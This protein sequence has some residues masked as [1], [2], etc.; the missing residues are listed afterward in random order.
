MDQPMTEMNEIQC[1]HSEPALRALPT[2]QRVVTQ[3]KP[4]MHKSLLDHLTTLQ[5]VEHTTIY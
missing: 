5:D 4:S 2:L 1:E 3:L